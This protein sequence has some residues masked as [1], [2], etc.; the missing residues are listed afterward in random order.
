M[1]GR[2]GR[3]WL[4]AWL[5]GSVLGIVNGVVRELTYKER[6]GE[7]TANQL[8]GLTLLVLLAAYFQVLQR[9]WPLPSRRVALNVGLAWAVLTVGFEFGFGHWVDRKSWSELAGNYDLAEGNLWL[10]VL[11]WISVGPAVTQA[12]TRSLQ[13]SRGLWPRRLGRPIS[14]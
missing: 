11:A 9:R 3:R 14:R 5:G 1:I 6:V 12:T 8:S 10:V 4:L 2:N 13:G 7:A